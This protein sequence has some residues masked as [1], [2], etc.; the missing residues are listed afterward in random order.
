MRPPFQGTRSIPLSRVMWPVETPL[1]SPGIVLRIIHWSVTMPD[2]SKKG[3]DI[4]LF[5]GAPSSPRPAMSSGSFTRP[6]RKTKNQSTR[7]PRPRRP[8]VTSK[9][10][11]SDGDRGD[12]RQ[13]QQQVRADELDGENGPT[14]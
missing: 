2:G 8:G 6:N 1:T 5:V 3:R 9:R 14:P 10:T 13:G 7:P 11:A 12:R 4:V